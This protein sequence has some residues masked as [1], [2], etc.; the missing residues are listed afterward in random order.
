MAARKTAKKDGSLLI[1]EDDAG[2]QKQLRWSFED[3]DVAVADD[4]ASTLAQL[5][6]ARPQV[7][8]LDLG[9]PPDPDGPRIAIDSPG[10][11]S[12]STSRRA[13]TTLSPLA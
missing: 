10:R 2:L 13:R 3:Y 6:K 5:A 4:Q 1:V 8:L 12:R 7:V 11:I 9:L